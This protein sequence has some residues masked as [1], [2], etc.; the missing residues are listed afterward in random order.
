[1]TNMTINKCTDSG[2]SALCCRMIELMMTLG[3][4]VRFSNGLN[5]PPIKLDEP[6]HRRNPGVY[7][8][9]FIED[10]V[11]SMEGL[12]P[13]QVYINGPCPHLDQDFNCQIHLS[14]SAC[15]QF[16]FNGLDCRKIRQEKKIR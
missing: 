14:I 12:P 3:D 13:I 9:D 5:P 2:C 8:R 15:R 10:Q 1:M 6:D 4:F 7:Y 11:I 16:P